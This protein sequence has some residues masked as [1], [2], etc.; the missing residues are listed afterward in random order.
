MAPSSEYSDSS[1]STPPGAVCPARCVRAHLVARSLAGAFGSR[2]RSPAGAAR[3][4]PRNPAWEGKPGAVE[5]SQSCDALMSSG[6]VA[7]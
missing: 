1:A 7:T 4:I 3:V 5:T 2:R 6:A